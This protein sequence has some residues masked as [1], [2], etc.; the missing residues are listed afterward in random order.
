MLERLHHTEEGAV[1]K[2]C[3]AYHAGI[4]KGTTV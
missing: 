1:F 4:I 3:S 2:S